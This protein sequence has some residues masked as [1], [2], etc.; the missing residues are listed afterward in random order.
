MWFLFKSLRVC[1]ATISDEAD[2]HLFS[3]VFFKNFFFCLF[4][5]H[6]HHH[7]YLLL[8]LLLILRRLD[9]SSFL[10]FISFN[11]NA[12]YTFLLFFSLFNFSFGFGRGFTFIFCTYVH[13]RARDIHV[14]VFSCWFFFSSFLPLSFSLCLTLC[15]VFISYFFFLFAIPCVYLIRPVFI[16]SFSFSTTST[17][18]H[19]LQRFC[20]WMNEKMARSGFVVITVATIGFL[21]LSRVFFFIMLF[22][23][24]CNLLIAVAFLTLIFFFCYW[25]ILLGHICCLVTSFNKFAHSK[26]VSVGLYRST[27]SF[28]FSHVKY[29]PIS[30]ML[31]F[32]N[33]ILRLGIYCFRYFH[34]LRLLLLLLSFFFVI[35]S[36]IHT[37]FPS[38]LPFTF[39][40]IRKKK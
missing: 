9:L 25:R 6:H 39:T 28:S 24:F 3:L 37:T 5:H 36:S 19:N 32:Y 23:I 10:Y 16:V 18:G 31:L 21:F 34:P 30:S 12:I 27:D 20:E 13:V 1:D 17:S 40:L 38:A 35:R 8:L 29:L 14:F 33:T 22:S 2:K 11:R 15:V 4:L 7:Q 26:D